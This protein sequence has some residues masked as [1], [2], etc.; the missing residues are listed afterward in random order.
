G[1]RAPTPGLVVPP[2]RRRVVLLWLAALLGV[3]VVAGAAGDSPRRGV[4]RPHRRAGAS[5]FAVS[6]CEG[7]DRQRGQAAGQPP[8]P[9]AIA[10][11]RFAISSGGTSSTWVMMLHRCPHGS[12][13]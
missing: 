12:S 1:T 6:A 13:I 8:P 5:R 3:A 2:H 7:V 10:A 9:S 4:G 11:A